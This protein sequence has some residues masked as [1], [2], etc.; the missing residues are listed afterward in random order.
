M[1]QKSPS[2]EASEPVVAPDHFCIVV[3]DLQK[4]I[5]DYEALGFTV[6][7]GVQKKN[8]GNALIGL[9]D[10]VYIELAQVPRTIMRLLRMSRHIGLLSLLLSGKRAMMKRIVLHWGNAEAGQWIDWCLSTRALEDSIATA[11]AQA[12]PIAPLPFTF[13]RPTADGGMAKWRMTGTID[14][15]LPFLIEDVPGYAPRVPLTLEHPHKNGASQLLRVVVGS[16]DPKETL[17]GLSVICGIAA[18]NDRI[19]IRG[20]DFIVEHAPDKA[21][22]GPLELVLSTTDESHAGQLLDTRLTGGAK[23]RLES[24]I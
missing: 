18:D 15:G 10:G 2:V 17:A 14:T 22:A 19:T 13:Q 4:A 23:I 6:L 9:A 3:D 24:Q 20:V 21:M 16:S 8:S 11:Q 7:P 1:S 5:Q 12:V